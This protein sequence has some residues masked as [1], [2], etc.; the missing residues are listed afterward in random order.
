MKKKLKKLKR[1]F[2]GMMIFLLLFSVSTVS[3]PVTEVVASPNV[4]PEVVD[5]ILAPGESSLPIEKTVETP[6][7]PPVPDIV[8]AFDA[9]GSMRYD[10]E[11]VKTNAIGI[12][13]TVLAV[14]PTAQFGVS[15]Y[16]D[17][18][19]YDPSAFDML[20][21]VTDQ[22]G[23]VSSA[24]DSMNAS[25]G[26]DWPEAQ[27]NALYQL[28]DGTTAG[29]RD[30]STKIIVWIGDAPG[31][32]P[33]NGHSLEEVIEILEDKNI[34]VIAVSTGRY[35]GLDNTEGF[36]GA[37]VGQATAITEATGGVLLEEIAS[38]DVSDA[39]LEGLDNLPVTVIPTV[40]GCD[41][42][43]VTFSPASQTVTS[44]DMALFTETITVPN[45]ALLEGTSVE[46][47]VIFTDEYGN[48]IGDQVIKVEIPDTT[49]PVLQCIAG[50][51]TSGENIPPAG[52]K[53]P[54]QNEDGFY[55][56]FATDN[57]DAEDTLDIYINGFGAFESG[58]T[59]KITEAPG[60]KEDKMQKIGSNKLDFVVAHLILKTD[61]VL[62][63][64]DSAGNESSITCY[65]PPVPK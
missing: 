49:A 54:G 47:T 5:L 15:Q 41:P 7:I 17:F 37:E 10:I 50:V 40:V 51:N 48:E 9:T 12:M 32:D 53:S 64:T 46:C 33:S 4:T 11:N 19:T 38:E 60:A 29:Y 1:F 45:D 30:D 35:G 13:N 6:E 34:K 42:L 55:Q 31:H 2:S 57:V 27:L 28:A 36:P 18:N 16:R 8:F 25:G 44:G 52:E 58:D 21:V 22:P 61:A 39:I 14:Q 56:I 43:D 59:V 63:V 24:I 23:L 26:A 3:T 62:T 20:Q 65:V